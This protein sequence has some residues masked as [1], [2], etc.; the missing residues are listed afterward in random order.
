MNNF[1]ERINDINKQIEELTAQRNAIQKEKADEIA[2][3]KKAED[4]IRTKE[5]REIERLIG[6]F[7]KKYN[8][9]YTLTTKSALFFP[10]SRF[11]F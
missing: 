8:S 3:Q 2:A 6:E 4:E 1:D 9:E 5:I 7:N 10:V 11:F